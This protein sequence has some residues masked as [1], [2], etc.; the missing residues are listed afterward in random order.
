MSKRLTWEQKKIVEHTNG[1]A[2]VKAVPGSGKTTA[3]VKRVE[4][5]VKDGVSHRSILILMYNKSAEE[6][7]KKK[8]K[9]VFK[10]HLVPDVRTFHSLACKITNYGENKNLIKK[11]TLLLPEN[12][13]YGGLVRLAYQEGFDTKDSDISVNDIEELEL[14]IDRCRAEAIT[15]QDAIHDP[16]FRHHKPE[17]IRAYSRYCTLLEEAGLRTF[18]DSLIEAISLLKNNPELESHYTHVIVDEYQDVNF[19]QHEM[20]CQLAKP[21]TSVM[22]VGDVNQCIYQWR[23]ARP[24]FITRLFEKHFTKTK[25]YHLSCTFRLG[26]R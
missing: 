25:V 12:P 5:L 20:T 13:H 19:I 9:T 17:F 3:L 22:A 10:S 24:D 2:L 11:K 1:H 15:P 26:I 8:L 7:F 23:G 14:F 16:T 21:H 4:K 18:D 6:S